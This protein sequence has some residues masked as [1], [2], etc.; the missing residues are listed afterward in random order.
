M[1][2]TAKSP[3]RVEPSEPEVHAAWRGV[4]P[5]RSPREILSRIV[6]GDPLRM[7]ARVGRRLESEAL[8]I[9]ADRVHLRALALCA[10]AA[11]RYRGQPEI[12]S[13]LE[14]RA[15]EALREVLEEG[16]EAPRPD[17]SAQPRAPGAFETLAAP[18][19]LDPPEMKRVCARFN[20]LPFPE[21]RAFFELVL[22][23]RSLDDLARTNAES[24]TAIARRARRALETLLGSETAGGAGT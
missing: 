19:G 21:R 3:A 4:V 8:L 18:L 10:R 22:H 17:D 12:E 7:R 6:P 24:A 16:E 11:V 14:A 13:W 15:E 1:E 23:A 2:I 5:G 9:D 20:R